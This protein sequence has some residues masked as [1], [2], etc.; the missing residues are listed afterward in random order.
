GA[1]PAGSMTAK[2]AA[3]GGAS[4]LMVEK[5]QEIGSP[6]RCG[7]GLSRASLNEI[8]VRPDKKWIATEVDG[9]KIVSPGGHA[10][11]INERMAGNEV[12]MVLERDM[13]DKALAADAAKAGAEIMLKTAAVGLIKEGGAVKRVKLVSYGKTIDVSAGCVVGADGFES[14]VGR[15]AGIDTTLKPSDVTSCFQYRLTNID[16]DYKYCEFIVGSAAPGG[17][18]WIFPKDEHTANVGI[19]V[20]LSKLK[21]PGQVKKYLDDFIAG[22]ERLRK[23]QPLDAVSGAVSVSPPVE[24]AVVNG[25]LLVG[26][27]A[28]IIDPITG[29]GIHNA[30]ISGTFA[31]K[32][33]SKAAETGDFTEST[34]MEY[35]RLWRN[36]LEN[37]LWRN[38]MA[39]EKLITLSDETF[40]KI[41]QT[42]AEV[43]VEK[44]S[45]GNILA[46]IKK[47][48]PELVKEFEEFI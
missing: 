40:D 32:V 11:I 43:G 8:G 41:I 38:W 37:N 39:K 18:V 2:H 45:V 16:H 20:L 5:R 44:M 48:Y 47:K 36:R 4:V 27:A 31:G 23:G 12:G 7:E 9:A 25:L 33:L 34:L 26:D 30:C 35:E 28:R 19:G 1:G 24:K 3:L 17:Y 21:K 15:W 29:G 22:D 46:V 13:F 14:Q 6:V 42:L 10:F